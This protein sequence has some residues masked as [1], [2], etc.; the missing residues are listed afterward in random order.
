LT[1]RGRTVPRV[2]SKNGLSVSVSK[3]TKQES[4]IEMLHAPGGITIEEIAT[5]LEWAAHTVRGAMGGPLVNRRQ[6][7]FQD[8]RKARSLA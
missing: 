5:A 2:V 1:S 6:W 3:G 8:Q 7:Q 4:M